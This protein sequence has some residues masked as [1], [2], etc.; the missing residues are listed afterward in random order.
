MSWSKIYYK[1]LWNVLSVVVIEYRKNY[2]L[3]SSLKSKEDIFIIFNYY[4]KY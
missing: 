1:G 2:F 4:V 3:Y